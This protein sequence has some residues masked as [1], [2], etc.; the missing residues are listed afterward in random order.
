VFRYNSHQ[1]E[2]NN[3]SFCLFFAKELVEQRERLE[4]IEK[5]L[6]G[7]DEN[8]IG[9]QKHLN[10]LGS[11]FG[12]IKNY[13]SSPKSAFHKSASDPQL[14]HADK[15]KVTPATSTTSR[16]SSPKDDSDTYLGKL[17]NEMDDVERAIDDGFRKFIR[18][19]S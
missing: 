11:I 13:F 5:R 16:P 12:G 17:S 2:S 3:Y 15:K 10:K 1:Y 14:S 18:F 6:D 19:Q 7:I 9:A 4:N 8:L